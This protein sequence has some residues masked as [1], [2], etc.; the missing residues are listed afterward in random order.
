MA[1]Q[2]SG[3]LREWSTKREME[4]V[5]VLVHGSSIGAS[6]AVAGEIADLIRRKAQSGMRAVLGLAS[7]STPHAVYDEL[8]RLH[9][10]DGLSFANVVS[11]NLDE[12]WPMTPDSLQSYRR[13]VKECLFDH[14][15]IDPANVHV[16]DGR[17]EHDGIVAYCAE[18]EKRIRDAGGIDYQILGVGRTGHIGFNEPGSGR[19]SRTRLITLDRVT[20]MDAASDFFGEPNV[21]KQALTMGVGTILDA[22]RVVLMAFGEHKAAIIRRAVEGEVTSTVAAS[23]LQGHAGATFVLDGAA[24]AELTRFRAPWLLEHDGGAELD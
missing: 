8:V 23:F 2:T 18:Y 20:R 4:R 12:Y 9:R 10:V 19:E 15:D 1:H 7:G 21:P 16:P 22:E 11:F 5:P 14:V 6:R 13:F 24:A 3:A 17:V